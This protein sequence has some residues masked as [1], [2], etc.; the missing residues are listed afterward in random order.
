MASITNSVRFIVLA[1]ALFCLIELNEVAAKPSGRKFKLFKCKTQ[2]M[3][4]FDMCVSQ[5]RNVPEY[6]VCYHAQ[7][8]CKSSCR[9]KYSDKPKGHSTFKS[10]KKRAVA[11]S[12]NI[13]EK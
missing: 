5:V 12:V 9:D 2:C 1:L 10:N 3:T 8:M 7:S 13:R 11:K 6:I 4:Y